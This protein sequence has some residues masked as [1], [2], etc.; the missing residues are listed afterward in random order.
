MQ[1]SKLRQRFPP[2]PVFARD[3]KLRLAP[4]K[5]ISAIL[6]LLLSQCVSESSVRKPYADKLMRAYIIPSASTLRSVV[7]ADG[8]ACSV[9]GK[10]FETIGFRVCS[11]RVALA[12]EHQL[13]Y[14]GTSTPS[15]SSGAGALINT[16]SA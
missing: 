13:H 8:P 7:Y 12:A 6:D 9:H 4:E 11:C 5:A 3:A 2:R 1:L 15:K 16:R 10:Q 14:S